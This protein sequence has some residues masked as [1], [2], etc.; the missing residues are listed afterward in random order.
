[1]PLFFFHIRGVRQELSCDELGLEFPDLKTVYLNALCAARV[2]GAELE[3]CDRNPRGCTIEVTSAA[4]EL[5]FTLPFSKALDDQ[6][7]HLLP[8]YVQ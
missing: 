4:G 3:A 6:V 2:V 8:R 1:M 7:H 5:V